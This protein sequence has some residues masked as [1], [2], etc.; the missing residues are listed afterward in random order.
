MTTLAISFQIYNLGSIEIAYNVR[1]MKVE[2][3]LDNITY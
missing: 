1:T 3:D 2:I